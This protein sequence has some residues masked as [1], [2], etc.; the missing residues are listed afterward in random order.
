[1]QISSK[2]SEDLSFGFG[3]VMEQFLYSL[4]TSQ[5][6]PISSY[7]LQHSSYDKQGNPVVFLQQKHVSLQL[8][9]QILKSF[10][11][12]PLVTWGFGCILLAW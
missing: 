7:F 1:M 3:P 2:Q 12:N 10:L 11:G 9:F 5:I 6:S 4:L 8:P